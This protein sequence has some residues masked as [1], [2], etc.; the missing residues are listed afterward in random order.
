[1]FIHYMSMYIYMP[2]V[3]SLNIKGCLN[4]TGLFCFC[5]IFFYCFVLGFFNIKMLNNLYFSWYILAGQ[6]CQPESA[7]QTDITARVG[8]P[9][10][11]DA[12]WVWG[13]RWLDWGVEPVY[14]RNQAQTTIQIL[15]WRPGK[16]LSLI[17]HGVIIS[18]GSVFYFSFF[19][20][21]VHV[22]IWLCC[23]FYI[24]YAHWSLMTQSVEFIMDAYSKVNTS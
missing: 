16:W 23:P 13:G 3:S 8:P 5:F 4:F 6:H 14:C 24:I 11:W 10:L 7:G 9:V 22:N 20:L 15:T 21:F 18:N 19:S 1:M 2:L 12:A 17:Q